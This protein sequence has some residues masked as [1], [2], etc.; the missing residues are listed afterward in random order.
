MRYTEKDAKNSFKRLVDCLG[1]TIHCWEQVN[2][3]NKSTIGAWEFDYNPIYGG[4]VINEIVNEQGG[5][6]HPFGS[7]RLKPFEFCIAVNMIINYSH[8]QKSEIAELKDKLKFV[9]NHSIAWQDE[10]K[11][12]KN[13]LH[14][15]NMQIKDLKA[16]IEEL[17]TF[18]NT[19]GDK[20]D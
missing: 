11:D 14:R 12:L 13:K 2:G 1:K 7:T 3:K 17:E 5:I 8:A 6:D 10:A 9:N 15:R 20:R 4:A 19:F 18:N 16:R